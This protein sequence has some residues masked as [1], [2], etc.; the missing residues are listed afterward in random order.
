MTG[1]EARP[2]SESRNEQR[3]RRPAGAGGE[4]C[5]RPGSRRSIEP[6]AARRAGGNC[7]AG[8][9]ARSSLLGGSPYPP[10]RGAVS[11]LHARAGG[12]GTW[13]AYPRRMPI[14]RLARPG[15]GLARAC[16]RP[17]RHLDR[18]RDVAW[19]DR[20][21]TMSLARDRGAAYSRVSRTG[22]G[23]RALSAGPTTAAQLVAGARPPDFAGAVGRR[24]RCRRSLSRVPA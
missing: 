22:W 23:R 2:A 20:R 6:G 19:W 16:R 9:S 18:A 12:R 14:C 1:F 13:W 24:R 17:G 3:P 10:R 4:R 21:F 8:A 11:R 5:T 7:R 15:S